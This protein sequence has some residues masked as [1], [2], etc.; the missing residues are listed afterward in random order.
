MLVG[1]GQAEEWRRGA[2][3]WWQCGYEERLGRRHDEGVEEEQR[4]RWLWLGDKRKRARTIAEGVR[5]FIPLAHTGHVRYLRECHFLLQ[6][7]FLE[8]KNPSLTFLSTK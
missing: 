1:R 5:D 7:C 2:R 6:A 8:S 3:R 4:R